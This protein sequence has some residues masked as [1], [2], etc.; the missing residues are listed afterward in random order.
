MGASAKRAQS[1]IQEKMMKATEREI[2][3]L[4]NFFMWDIPE[5]ILFFS[6]STNLRK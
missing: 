3:K 4:K 5:V 6:D 2:R 1:R